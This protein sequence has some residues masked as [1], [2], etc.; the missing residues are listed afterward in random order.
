MKRESF[1]ETELLQGDSSTVA[2]K[3]GMLK[4]CEDLKRRN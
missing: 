4:L 1:Q 2:L 3:K